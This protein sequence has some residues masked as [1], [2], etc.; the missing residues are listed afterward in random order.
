MSPG[1]ENRR[2]RPLGR[3]RRGPWPQQFTAWDHD[4][5]TEPPWA[6]AVYPRIPAVRNTG[7]KREGYSVGLLGIVPHTE[8]FCTDKRVGRQQVGEF[9]A[10]GVH[11]GLLAWMGGPPPPNPGMNTRENVRGDG[12][13]RANVVEKEQSV[14]GF[15]DRA[16]RLP[17]RGRWGVAV[18]ARPAC[19]EWRLCR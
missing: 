9:T 2:A 16:P 13:V 4:R 6:G 8:W 15:S 11:K 14:P 5:E 7:R 17:P 10:R 12:R 18:A 19:Y 1:A 3:V